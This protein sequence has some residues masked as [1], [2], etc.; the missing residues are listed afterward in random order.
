MQKIIIAT[1][2]F[3]DSLDAPEVCQAIRRGIKKAVPRAL[4]HTLPLGDGGEGTARLLAQAMQAEWISTQVEDPLGRPIRAGYGWLEPAKTAYL[5]MAEA[6]G[7]Q[8]LASSARDPFRTH[9]FGF[10]QLLKHALA[11]GAKK[12]IIG[13]GGSATSE[14]GMGMAIAFGYQFFD[15]KG[16]ELLPGGKQLNNIH[17]IS[18]PEQHPVPEDCEVSILCDVN[19]PLYGPQGAAA[20]FAPQKGASP[21]Q[22]KV[23]DKGLRQLAVRIQRD[24]HIDVHHLA[25]GGAAGGLGAGLVAFARGVL[26]PGIDHI[27]ELVDFENFIQGADV[28]I[29]GEGKLDAQT[30]G[31]KLIQGICRKAAEKNIPVIA[32]CGSL[33]VSPPE[34]QKIGLQAAFS[35][36]SGP[37]SLDKALKQTAKRLEEVAENLFRAINLTKA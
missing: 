4:I 5:D 15:E 32:L 2:S 25:G 24:L 12:L 3:K 1:D 37:K 33:E 29:T 36:S 16:K 20:V 35:I 17:R 9:T 6:S 23:L 27:L 21:N 11:K 34:I 31:G 7:L 10:G 30:G 8:H 13:I 14:G 28:L 26:R 18:P 22:I 19:H